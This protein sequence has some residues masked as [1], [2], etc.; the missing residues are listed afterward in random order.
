MIKKELSSE[1]DPFKKPYWN[2]MQTLGWVYLRS[3]EWVRLTDDDNTNYGSFTAMGA[4]P[5][6]EAKKMEFSSKRPS[7]ITLGMWG[8]RDGAF[9]DGVDPMFNNVDE[10]KLLF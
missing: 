6:G 8:Y 4:I 7:T 3:V 5:G 10:A 2:K 1:G 9:F